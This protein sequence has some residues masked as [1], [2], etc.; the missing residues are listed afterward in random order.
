MNLCHLISLTQINKLNA[1]FLYS[2][3]PTQQMLCT[4]S[5]L[6]LYTVK[7]KV[8][9]TSIREAAILKNK[10]RSGFMVCRQ[11]HKVTTAPGLNISC[12]FANCA[13]AIPCYYQNECNYG[14]TTKASDQLQEIVTHAGIH[15]KAKAWLQIKLSFKDFY[16]QLY[17]AYQKCCQ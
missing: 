7:N 8:N 10:N 12:A 4:Y 9:F 5:V 13:T 2:T 14:I 15:Y 17:N 1:C 16:L 6:S 3:N 11:K